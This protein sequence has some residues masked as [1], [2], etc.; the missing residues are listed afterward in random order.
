MEYSD[1]PLPKKYWLFF[2]LIDFYLHQF[3]SCK[4]PIPTKSNRKKD[5]E[6]KNIKTSW[7]SSYNWKSDISDFK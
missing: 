5:Y 1:M 7:N 6:K 2:P 4:D 3:T